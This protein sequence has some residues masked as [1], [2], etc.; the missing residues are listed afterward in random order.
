MNNQNPYD[1]QPQ[2]PYQQQNYQAPMPP[3][4][5]QAPM[6]P[7]A[8]FFNN[9]ILGIIACA[10]S[11]IGFA[12]V[13]VSLMAARLPVYGLILNILAIILSAG[14]CFLSFMLGNKRI[15]SG[16]PRGMVSTLGIIFG[17]A[18]LVIGLFAIILTS[19]SACDTCKS[20][21]ERAAR[22]ALGL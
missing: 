8:P 21:E 1:Q 2:Q 5:P 14:G 7:K 9:D 3:M 22:I 17:L 12:L 19:C 15:Q 13:L 16:A 18:G 6:T 20:A 11:I 4:P 10:A